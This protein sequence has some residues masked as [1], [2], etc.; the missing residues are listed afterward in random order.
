MRIGYMVTPAARI[1][2]TVTPKMAKI[3]GRKEFHVG[4]LVKHT[5]EC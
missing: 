2:Y 5:K 3:E 4:E 1:G